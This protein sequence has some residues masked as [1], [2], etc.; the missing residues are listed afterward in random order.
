M[1]VSGLHRRARWDAWA[2]EETRSAAVRAPRPGDH[3]PEELPHREA[4]QSYP[5]DKRDAPLPP[6]S[7][8]GAS[9][10]GSLDARRPS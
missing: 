2:F 9:K 4:Q 7:A 1:N 3:P 8:A 10:G 5:Q 6:A